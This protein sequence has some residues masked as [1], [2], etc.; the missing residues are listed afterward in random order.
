MDQI[1]KDCI[2]AKDLGLSYGHYKALSYDPMQHTP[3]YCTPPQRQQQTRRF[4][5]AEAF[6][7]WQQGYSDGEIAAAIGVSK[8]R[9]Q[10]W[11]SRMKLPPIT[12]PGIDRKKYRLV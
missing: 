1:D 11:R 10:A 5:D 4:T 3:I 9:I 12:E 8:S 7:L 2:A 6:A